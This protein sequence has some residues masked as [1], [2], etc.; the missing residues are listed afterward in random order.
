MNTFKTSDNGRKFIETWEGLYLHTY[1]DGTGV[2]TIGY[3]HTTA[4]G[5]P[6]VMHGQTITS[7]Q[8]DEILASDLMRVEEAVNRLVLVTI[9]QNQFDALV[10]FDFNTGGLAR[11]SV[12]SSINHNEFDRVVPDLNLW[13]MAGKR[14]MQ[15]LVKRRR[16]EGILF[17]TGEIVGP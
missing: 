11:S 13:I 17:N 9:N 15:G 6:S 16:A 7:T 8:A 10:S 1:N 2:L 5:P 12:L 3:G 14:V 4:A